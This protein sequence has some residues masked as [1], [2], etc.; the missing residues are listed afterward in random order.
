MPADHFSPPPRPEFGP[1]PDWLASC[2]ETALRDLQGQAPV[3]VRL[4]Y[5]EIDEGTLW[6][7][8]IDGDSITG[9]GLRGDRGGLLVAHIAD[10]LQEQF[11]PETETA[12]GEPRP[13]CPGHTHPAQ[14]AL[15]GH[16]PWWTCPRDGSPVARIGEL[17]RD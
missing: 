13:L 3:P 9:V 2:V 17:A 15:I 7:Q 8:E 10:E 12:W 16:E 5:S 14:A 11:F 6:V 1:L 4:G